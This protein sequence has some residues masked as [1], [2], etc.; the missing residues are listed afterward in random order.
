MQSPHTQPERDFC[1]MGKHKTRS[2]EMPLEGNFCDKS[3]T[4]LFLADSVLPHQCHSCGHSHRTKIWQFPV[5]GVIQSLTLAVS[6]I[7]MF[8]SPART[9]LLTPTLTMT[10]GR[11]CPWT[12]TEQVKSP[13]TVYEVSWVAETLVQQQLNHCSLRAN[14]I[15]ECASKPSA[16][17][18]QL[19]IHKCISHLWSRAVQTTGR[20]SPLDISQRAHELKPCMLRIYLEFQPAMRLQ[21]QGML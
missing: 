21:F 15:C 14:K 8:S 7:E 17:P 10:K 6:L 1:F 13:K 16:Y 18:D 20:K 11:I 5:S 2:G 4:V 12:N 3:D 9:S 19:V